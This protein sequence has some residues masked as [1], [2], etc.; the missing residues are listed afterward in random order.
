M[1]NHDNTQSKSS[2]KLITRYAR[3]FAPDDPACNI[4]IDLQSEAAGYVPRLPDDQWQELSGLGANGLMFY[5]TIPDDALLEELIQSGYYI[6]YGSHWVPMHFRDLYGIEEGD[7]KLL[8][9]L[10][11]WN[12]KYPGSVS[13]G[14]SSESGI[15]GLDWRWLMGFPDPG[16]TISKIEAYEITKRHYLDQ[17]IANTGFR[18]WFY[19]QKRLQNPRPLRETLYAEWRGAGCPPVEGLKPWGFAEVMDHACRTGAD[20]RDYSLVIGD[21]LQNHALNYFA[22]RDGLLLLVE[23]FDIANGPLIRAPPITFDRRQE[24]GH[25]ARADHESDL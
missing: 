17:S 22:D 11:A 20:V 6:Y 4:D 19:A 3:V 9:H 7:G 13:W 24:Q 5:P 14:C 2:L 12:K 23:A 25:R 16:N 8:D 1:T 21:G 15:D 10:R 18:V